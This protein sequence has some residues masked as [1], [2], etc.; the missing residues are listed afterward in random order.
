[1]AVAYLVTLPIP[2]PDASQK[3]KE[4]YASW[5]ESMYIPVGIVAF[6]VI[7]FIVAVSRFVSEYPPHPLRFTW[8]IG[9]SASAAAIIHLATLPVKGTANTGLTLLVVLGTGIVLAAIGFRREMRP[10]DWLDQGG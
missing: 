9:I 10:Q 7:P 2:K 6:V 4:S 3:T 1:M 8:S 5:K